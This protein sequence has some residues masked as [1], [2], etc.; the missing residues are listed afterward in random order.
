MTLLDPREIAEQLA[1][2][3]GWAREGDAI[4]KKYEFANFV[5]AMAFVQRVADRARRPRGAH[6][7]DRAGCEQRL[8][9]HCRRIGDINGLTSMGHSTQLLWESGQ[10]PALVQTYLAGKACVRAGR[11][12]SDYTPDPHNAGV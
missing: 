2:L 3:S 5:E 10:S 8:Q 11:G 7:G 12:L 6:D 4:V 9:I 1:G